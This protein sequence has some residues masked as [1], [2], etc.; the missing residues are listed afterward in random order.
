MK[1][2]KIR[3]AKNRVSR[4]LWGIAFISFA[5]LL[6][7]S[8]LNVIEFKL[9]FEGWWTLFLIIPGTAGIISGERR[10]LNFFLILIGC[11]Y[12]A[13]VYL[14][15]Y[16]NVSFSKIVLIL[17]LFV[18]GLKLLFF[19]KSKKAKRSSFDTF[20]HTHNG[21]GEFASDQK[22]DVI[23][24]GY[25]LDLRKNVFNSDIFITC[26][27]LFGG[28]EILVPSNVNVEASGKCLLGGVSNNHKKT[29][30][31]FTV[32]INY[33]CMLGAIEIN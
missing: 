10:G 24:S 19:S 30:G 27:V 22:I 2:L 32:Y 3:I 1:D 25:E 20:E 21:D 4:I 16:I 7:L 15:E 6:L 26:I 8:F 31:E 18:L 28:V 29:Q 12:L 14:E 11:S 23:F 17:I 33:D 13:S 9:F 5:V